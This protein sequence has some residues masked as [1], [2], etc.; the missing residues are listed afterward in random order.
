MNI[1]KFGSDE[2]ESCI[3]RSCIGV[4]CSLLFQTTVV[5]PYKIEEIYGIVSYQNFSVSF[6]LYSAC[7]PQVHVWHVCHVWI[8]QW[9]KWVNKCG[10]LQ[11]WIQHSFWH[12]NLFIRSYQDNSLIS[13]IYKNNLLAI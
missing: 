8:A 10:P 2:D 9:I 7:E 6:V 3:E 4:K 13:F 11:P 1:I 5:Y 12:E